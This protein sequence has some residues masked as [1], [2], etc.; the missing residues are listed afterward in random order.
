VACKTALTCTDIL[1]S[2]A[3]FLTHLAKLEILDVDTFRPLLKGT[4]LAKALSTKPGPWMKDALDVVMAWQ[5]RNPKSTDASAAIE[6]VRASREA[7]TDSELPSRLASHFLQLTI[8]PFFPQSKAN[9]NALEKSRQSAP[10]KDPTAQYALDLLEWSIGVLSRKEKEAKWHLLVPPILKMI[11]DMDAVWKAK[12]CHILGVLLK[13]M[14]RPSE[15]DHISKHGGNRQSAT[16]FLQRTGYHNVFTEGLLP[17]FTY[18]PTLTP[19]PEAVPLFRELLPTLTTLALLLPSESNTIS[20]TKVGLLDQVVR[21]GIFS[22]LAHFP[23][24]SSYPEL[25]TVMMSQLQVLLGHLG[26]ESVKHLPRVVPLLSTILQEPF[27][28]SHK[29]LTLSTLKALQAVMLNAWPRV[30]GHRVVIMMGLCV[31]WRRC[32]ED[33]T[34]LAH[35]G[36]VKAELQESVAM[37]DAVMHAADDASVRAQWEEEKQQL[38]ETSLACKGLFET[39]GQDT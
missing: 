6:A 18:I 4:D 39:C 11:D 24:P 32:M 34:S 8:P 37:L 25:A 22:P 28:A 27:V 30:A 2:Y 19:E 10:W 26:I 17:L 35:V 1:R 9:S 21:E 20:G 23:T 14:Q 38:V 36:E 12:G 29:A 16:N 7:Q 33:E 31:C 5:L 13:E 3:A 15:M